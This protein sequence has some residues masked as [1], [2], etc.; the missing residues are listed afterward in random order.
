MDAKMRVLRP[1]GKIMSYPQP[2]VSLAA[3]AAHD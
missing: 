2:V 1:N 3:A